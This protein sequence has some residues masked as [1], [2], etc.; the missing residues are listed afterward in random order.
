MKTKSILDNQ[1]ELEL[2]QKHDALLKF[3]R[4]MERYGYHKDQ[5]VRVRALRVL[6]EVG[7][8]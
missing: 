4:E 6:K 5:E 7:A 3:A 2:K 8:L 1:I